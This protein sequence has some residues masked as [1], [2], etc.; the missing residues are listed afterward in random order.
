[1]GGRTVGIQQSRHRMVVWY[2]LGFF[3]GILYANFIAG[4]YI[5][6][7][8]IFHE[9]FLSQYIQIEIVKE[10]YLLYLVKCRLVPFVLLACAGYTRIRKPAAVACLL[11]TGFSGGV[12]AVAAVLRMGAKGILLCLAGIFPQ[13]I[14]YLLGYAVVLW[15]LYQYPHSRWDKGKTIFVVVMMAAGVLIEAYVNPIIVKIIMRVVM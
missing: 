11:W 3:C 10:E 2:M 14:F 5:T 1:M 12:L 15:Y 6:V 8:G 4:N 9:Y 7:T 13:I